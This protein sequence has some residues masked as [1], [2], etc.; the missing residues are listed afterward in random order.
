MM[1]Y[2]ETKAEAFALA[3]EEQDE[4]LNEQRKVWRSEIVEQ[5]Q[6]V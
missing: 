6:E 1:N 4:L 5:E 3:E 2:E